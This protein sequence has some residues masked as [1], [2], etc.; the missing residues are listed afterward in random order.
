M[1]HTDSLDMQGRLTIH[2]FDPTGQLIHTTRN[3]NA[4]V[5][6]G[7]DLVAKLFVKEKIDPIEYIAVGTGDKL[8]DL[9]DK[10]L[11]KE[12]FRKKL[13]EFDFSKDIGDIPIEVEDSASQKKV[14]QT[15]RRIMLSADLEFNEPD[16]AKNS[17]QPY[18]LREAGLF[19]AKEGGVM[20]NRVV[21]PN[22]SKTEAFKL[23]L[24]WEIIF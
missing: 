22:I 9:N 8:I 14:T 19:N 16:P 7:R 20:Y 2:T 12:I 13:K 11:Q 23:T 1:K 4:I 6:S 24:V 10:T 3:R 5:Y 17:G 18:E 15:R 21:F